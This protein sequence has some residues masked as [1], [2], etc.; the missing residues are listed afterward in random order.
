M[1]EHLIFKWQLESVTHTRSRFWKDYEIRSS[2]IFRCSCWN[3]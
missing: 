1:Q 3:V 2:R